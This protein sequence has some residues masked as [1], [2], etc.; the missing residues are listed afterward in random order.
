MKTERP[1]PRAGLVS[2]LLLVLVAGCT[3]TPERPD[4]PAWSLDGKLSLRTA[5]ESRILTM[6]WT[7][8]PD[9]SEIDLKGPLG[10]RVARIEADVAGFTVVNGDGDF[11]YSHAQSLDFP[12]I[13]RIRLPWQA[14]SHWVR[15]LDAD[16][17][18]FPEAGFTG[19]D[20]QV[21][22]L[23]QDETGPR[24]LS[25]VHPGVQIRLSVTRW[26]FY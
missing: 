13:G 1:R 10:I 2:T 11:R 9:R 14:L 24:L 15:G 17:R 18:P 22:V 23:K 3:S 21:R 19:R 5:R 8:F 26:E 16:K 6:S 12:D 20:W 4:T 7:E 25:F